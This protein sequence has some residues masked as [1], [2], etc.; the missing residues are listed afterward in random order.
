MS[1]EDLTRFRPIA[2]RREAIDKHPEGYSREEIEQHFMAAFRF[3]A[4]II[5]RYEVDDTQEWSMSP[6]TG[7][8]WYEA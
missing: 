4:E 1:D 3:Y 8:M 6:R 7:E 5:A 2:A